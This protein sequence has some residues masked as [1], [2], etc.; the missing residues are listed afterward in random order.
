MSSVRAKSINVARF[1][2]IGTYIP[3]PLGGGQGGGGG[4]T[5]P[6]LFPLPKRERRFNS[7]WPS[8]PAISPT[9]RGARFFSAFPL[10][11]SL[12]GHFGKSFRWPVS[13]SPGRSIAP[14]SQFLYQ[15]SG[16][17]WRYPRSPLREQ[18]DQAPLTP[19]VPLD[20]VCGP[21]I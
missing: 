9:A 20:W 5:P 21:A 3:P 8:S 4:R 10:R 14:A 6:H 13:S 11:Q 19:L 17:L 12:A 2:N 18:R 16:S 1:A 7:N 15:V